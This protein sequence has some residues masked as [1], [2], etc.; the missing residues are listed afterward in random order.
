MRVMVSASA[1][2][3][4]FVG[5]A[6]LLGCGTGA[7][8]ESNR[9]R[10]ADGETRAAARACHQRV[11]SQPEYAHL[12]TKLSLDDGN[13]PLEFTTN[14]A[15]P[16]KQEISLLYK[17]HAD[18]QPC[19]KIAVE[20]LAQVHPLLMLTLVEY[21]SARD[22]LWAEAVKGGLTWG[23]FNQGLKDLQTQHQANGT[24][25]GHQITA[26][27]QNQ[28]A[29]EVQQRQHAAAAFQQ[30]ANQQEELANQRQA[31]NAMNA[32]RTINCQYV[33]NTAQCQSR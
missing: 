7:Q 21:L 32:P 18:F 10:T 17:Y 25:A 27:L 31:I 20:G 30:W 12:K 28:H 15:R 13:Y 14:T 33:G 2:L 29:F 16:T 8:V 22:K 23:Q 19:T 4:Q 1:Q 5:V 26:Q 11:V 24:R 9:M 3:A 6:M